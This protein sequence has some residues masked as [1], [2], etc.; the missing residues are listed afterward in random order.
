MFPLNKLALAINQ[1]GGIFV[2]KFR[3]SETPF[4]VT[5]DG[6]AVEKEM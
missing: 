4:S 3:F 5:K 6:V 2:S 1:N